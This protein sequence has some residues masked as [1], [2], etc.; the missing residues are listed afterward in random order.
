MRYSEN[1][2]NNTHTYTLTETCIECGK[3]S[4]VVVQ[5][6][7][8]FNWNNGA[9]V[10]VAFPYLTASERELMFMSHICGTCWEN[11]FADDEEF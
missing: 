11:L 7:D 10:Q 8:L 2:S 1:F 9:A 4:S 5:G 3:D 6:P